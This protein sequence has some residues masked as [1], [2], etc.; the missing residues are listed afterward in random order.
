MAGKALGELAARTGIQF[1]S[2][3]S[4]N[5]LVE[6]D[7]NMRPTGRLVL[8]DMSDLYVDKSFIKAIEGGDANLLKRFN[9]AENVK[10]YIVAAFGPLHG[11]AKPSW[12]SERQYSTWK[13]VFFSQFEATFEEVS[14][15]RLRDLKM[16]PYQSGD[17]FGT[18]YD[19]KSNAEF[20]TFFQMMNA[21]GFVR[22]LGG[23][24]TCNKV[25]SEVSGF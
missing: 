8:R 2:P 14:G 16:T 18:S 13:D 25:F 15:Y 4:Q 19:L 11:N 3:H 12:V 23:A 24:V 10:S 9:Q 22:N 17:Y 6:M 7:E 21:D 5:F 20:K 1:D